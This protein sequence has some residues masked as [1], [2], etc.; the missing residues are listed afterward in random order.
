MSIVDLEELRRLAS[1]SSITTV[2]VSCHSLSL[3]C[4]L[5]YCRMLSIGEELMRMAEEQAMSRIAVTDSYAY[6]AIACSNLFS[7]YL[8]VSCHVTVM[9]CWW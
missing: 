7:R 2:R 6:D 3:M 8:T 5:H 1:W 4:G 9:C